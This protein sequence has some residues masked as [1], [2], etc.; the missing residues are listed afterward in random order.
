MNIFQFLLLH[1]STPEHFKGKIFTLYSTTF[2][3][4]GDY[5]YL[6]LFRLLLLM[7]LFADITS[8]LLL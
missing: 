2:A 4:C 5:S 3:V 7:I 6:I 1:T 8:V